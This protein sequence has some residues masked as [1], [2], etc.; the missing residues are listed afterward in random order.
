MEIDKSPD[1]KFRQGF[2]GTAPQGAKTGDKSPCLLW[3]GFLIRGEGRGGGRGWARGMTQ[4][5]CPSSWMHSQC[6][7]FAPGSSQVPFGFGSFCYRIVYNLPQLHMQ[8]VILV[9]CHLLVFCCRR[10]CMSS[11]STAA[12]GPR[13]QPVSVTVE[14]IHR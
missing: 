2:I 7:A 5:L 10:R 9:P 12:K 4:P 8:A 3:R 11:A 13:S 1:R 6:P 14:G